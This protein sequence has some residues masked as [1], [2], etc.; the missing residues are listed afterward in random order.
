MRLLRNTHHF[1]KQ[2]VN[3]NVNTGWGFNNW[4]WYVGAGAGALALLY[5]GIKIYV[6]PS[7]VTNYLPARTPERGIFQILSGGLT[8]IF[9]GLTQL[10]ASS[11][12]FLNPFKYFSGSNGSRSL[13]YINTHENFL[14]N[15]L[16]WDSNLRNEAYFP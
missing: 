16:N 15:Q 10:N 5:L 13:E 1:P 12:S 2:P 7:T 8:S 11:F 6:D 9:T 3:I 4:W 14:A